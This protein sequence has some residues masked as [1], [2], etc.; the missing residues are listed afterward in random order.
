MMLSYDWDSALQV[1]R[2]DRAIGGTDQELVGISRHAGPV[3]PV[4]PTV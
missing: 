1:T 2:G 3:H 4:R